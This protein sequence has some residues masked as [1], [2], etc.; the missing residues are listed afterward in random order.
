M[1][2]RYKCIYEMSRVRVPDCNSH[3]V[4]GKELYD[5]A[6]VLGMTNVY[7]S[8]DDKVSGYDKDGYFVVDAYVYKR[9][10]PII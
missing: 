4:R 5:A 2:E 7:V 10:T 1:N 9:D 3:R 8:I 6:K